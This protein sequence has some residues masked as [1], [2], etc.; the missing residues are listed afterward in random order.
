VIGATDREETLGLGHRQRAQGALGDGDVLAVGG[1][2]LLDDPGRESVV[3]A[4]DEVVA[5]VR[6]PGNGGH[7]AILTG[8]RGAGAIK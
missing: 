4:H 2:Q 6:E 7:G 8:P 5:A 3:A 1:G